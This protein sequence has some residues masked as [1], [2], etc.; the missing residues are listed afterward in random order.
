MVCSLLLTAYLNK[1]RLMNN[2]NKYFSIIDKLCNNDWSITH[3]NLKAPLCSIVADSAG[4]RAA[5]IFLCFSSW[6]SRKQR[7]EIWHLALLEVK[8]WL[9]EA[10]GFTPSLQNCCEGWAL[11]TSV[12]AQFPSEV[13]KNN[14]ICKILFLDNWMKECRRQRCF[15]VLRMRSHRSPGMH[16]KAGPGSSASAARLCRPNHCIAA[17][18]SV[19]SRKNRGISS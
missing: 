4:E 17:N 6:P 18:L 2:S 10:W 8:V 7:L 12:L 11:R 16:G 3:Y 15:L 14:P 5:S 9:T 19:S 13:C 1:R